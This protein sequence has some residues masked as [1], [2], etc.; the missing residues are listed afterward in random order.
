M[1][2][3]QPYDSGFPEHKSRL[4]RGLVRVEVIVS[5]VLVVVLLALVSLQVFTRFVLHAPLIWTEEV[6][7]FTFVWFVFVAA[8]FVTARRREIVVTLYSA[9]K[10][11]RVMAG[12]DTFAALVSA[13]FATILAIG[14]VQLSIQV[15]KLVLP[16]SNI[17]QSVFYASAVIGFSLIAFHSLV[18][19]YLAVRYPSQHLDKPKLDLE[20]ID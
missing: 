7:R 10:T 3:I 12:I 17:P 6:A 18:N 11:G 15:S 1:S 8:T 5:V 19:A 14:S 9:K 2:E 16:A 13:V 4:Y 20:T